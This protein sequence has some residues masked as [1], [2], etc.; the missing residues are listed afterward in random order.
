MAGGGDDMKDEPRTVANIRT[1]LRIHLRQRGLSIRQFA[2]DA[3]IDHSIISR[4]LR[5]ERTPSLETFLRIERA[6]IG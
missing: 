6:I 4:F 1:A 3:G 5:G 2:N